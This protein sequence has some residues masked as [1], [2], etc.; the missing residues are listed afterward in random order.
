MVYKGLST[1]CSVKRCSTVTY[2]VS[3]HTAYQQNRYLLAEAV[4]TIDNGKFFWNDSV[5]LMLSLNSKRFE[6]YLTLGVSF[7]LFVTL[8]IA[9]AA[10]ASSI[11]HHREELDPRQPSE[12]INV[13]LPHDAKDDN[14]VEPSRQARQ[15]QMSYME[16]WTWL[17]SGRRVDLCSSGCTVGNVSLPKVLYKVACVWLSQ[18]S[19]C[20]CKSSAGR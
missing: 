7:S 5:S 2:L 4:P 8:A 19:C 17:E 1:H 20:N 9:A 18:K 3:F 16:M 13:P 14:M 10:I 6:F 11:Q 12:H 15:R